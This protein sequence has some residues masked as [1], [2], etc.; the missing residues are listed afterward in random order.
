LKTAAKPLEVDMLL[1][2]DPLQVAVLPQ[3]IL[4]QTD[5]RQTHRTTYA[6]HHGCSA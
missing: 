2:T 1:T 5:R 4:S 3:Y 6:L